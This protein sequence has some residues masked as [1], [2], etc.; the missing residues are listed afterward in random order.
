MRI[1]ND[2]SVNEYYED[3]IDSKYFKKDFRTEKF[4]QMESDLRELLAKLI[5]KRKNAKRTHDLEVL[6]H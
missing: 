2:S 3:S 6:G 5:E 1:A 4:N